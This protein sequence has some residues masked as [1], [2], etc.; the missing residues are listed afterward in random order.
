MLVALYGRRQN[1]LWAIAPDH[2]DEIMHLQFQDDFS[3]LIDLSSH[4]AWN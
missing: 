4:P 1:A 3:L 2:S